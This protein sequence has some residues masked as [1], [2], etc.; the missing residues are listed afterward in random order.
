M[1]LT[2]EEQEVL[3]AYGFDLMAQLEAMLRHIREYQRAL[4]TFRGT[5]PRQGQGSD[6][7]AQAPIVVMSNHVRAL[8][9]AS[10]QFDI[11][12]TEIEQLTACSEKEEQRKRT[13]VRLVPP[14]SARW[15]STPDR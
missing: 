9:E 10:R 1:S 15:H 3:E 4:Q 7:P 14:D 11:S 6:D 12:V 5:L 2:R 13:D 8:R